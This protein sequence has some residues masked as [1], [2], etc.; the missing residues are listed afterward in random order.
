MRDQ[1]QFN[2]SDFVTNFASKQVTKKWPLVQLSEND[3]VI[4]LFLIRNKGLAIYSPVQLLSSVQLYV[5]PWTVARQASLSI[6]NSQS[7]LK[8]MSIES[9]MPSNHLILCYPL[10]FLPSII[11]SIRLFSKE[12]V[13]CIRWPKYWSFSFSISTRESLSD[14]MLIPEIGTNCESAAPNMPVNLENSAVAPGLE[15][16]SF[17]SNPKERQCQRMLKLPHNCTHLTS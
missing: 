15:K 5:T 2:D 16:V 9:V 4:F 6:T 12:S 10:F 7:F 13:L 3:S 8:L 14:A 1:K 11:L 17:Y